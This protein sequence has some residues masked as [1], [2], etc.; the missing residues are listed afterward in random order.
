MKKINKL[1]IRIF[2]YFIPN[3]Q[4]R[5]FVRLCRFGRYKITG[6]NNVIM[7]AGHKLPRF[8]KNGNLP[9]NTVV[10]ADAVVTKT[11][12]EE[13]TILAGNPAKVIKRNVMWDEVSPYWKDRELRGDV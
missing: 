12:T 1:F 5:D 8:L 2:A 3:R 11:F 9:P 6:E 4:L 10:A 13:F 7:F